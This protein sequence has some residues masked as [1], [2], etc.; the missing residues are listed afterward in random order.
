MKILKLRVNEWSYINWCVQH[1]VGHVRYVLM[2]LKVLSNLK[3]A[4]L[5]RLTPLHNLTAACIIVNADWLPRF[6]E[7]T[8]SGSAIGAVTQDVFKANLIRM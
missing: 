2:F 5:H 4:S 6:M 8:N 7:P 3:K 1:V